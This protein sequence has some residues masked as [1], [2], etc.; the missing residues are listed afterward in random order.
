MKRLC[1]VFEKLAVAALKLKSTK[2]NFFC[3]MLAYLGHI[4]SEDG[5]ETDPKKISA[6]KTWPTP[7][8]VTEV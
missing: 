2:C 1:G 3:T 6:I 7:I 8:T 5:I 4:F